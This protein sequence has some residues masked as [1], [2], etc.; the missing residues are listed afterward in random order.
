MS[1]I[2]SD[3]PVVKRS[4]VG[5]FATAAG[6]CKCNTYCKCFVNLV[7]SRL[8]LLLFATVV[9]IKTFLHNNNTD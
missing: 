6:K 4:V 2:D 9:N 3:T 8:Q 1:G 7:K 5:H